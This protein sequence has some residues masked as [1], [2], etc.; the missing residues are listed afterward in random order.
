[1]KK[2]DKCLCGGKL[3]DVAVVRDGIHLLGQKC[4]K[5]NEIYF[6]AEE[7]LRYEM[8]TGKRKGLASVIVEKP[9]TAAQRIRPRI[10]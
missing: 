9:A 5:C 4:V 6:D 2:I 10:S 8:L 7:M 3:E 1:M